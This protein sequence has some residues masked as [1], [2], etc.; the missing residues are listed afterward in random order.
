[1]VI[2]CE[3]RHVFVVIKFQG[4]IVVFSADTADVNAQRMSPIYRLQGTE[5]NYF[6]FNCQL[7]R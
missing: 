7:I 5:I 2:F 6:V 3:L 1:M 4:D